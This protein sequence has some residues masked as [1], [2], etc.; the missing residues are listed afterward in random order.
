VT[1]VAVVPAAEVREVVRL[2][3]HTRQRFLGADP[4]SEPVPQIQRR[5]EAGG[6]RLLAVR[7]G[8]TTVAVAGYVPNRQNPRLADVDVLPLAAELTAELVRAVLGFLQRFERIVS[9]VKVVEHGDLREPAFRGC[10]FVQ[11][12]AL[13]RHTFARGAYHDQA[14]LH[15]RAVEE[16]ACHGC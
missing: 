3:A 4:V 11:I 5:F 16:D 2:I 10:G 7:D 6:V 1:S 12:G 13:R 8:A 9:F 15:G 14:V